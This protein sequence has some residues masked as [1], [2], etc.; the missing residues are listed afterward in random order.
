M[1]LKI[2]KLG[3]ASNY[4]VLTQQPLLTILITKLIINILTG[5]S[6]SAI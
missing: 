6:Q 2:G 4:F 3:G 5:L 1:R